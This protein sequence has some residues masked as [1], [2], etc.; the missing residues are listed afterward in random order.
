MNGPRRVTRD[1]FNPRISDVTRATSSYLMRSTP[2]KCKTKIKERLR[3]RS[4]TTLFPKTAAGFAGRPNDRYATMTDTTGTT[5]GGKRSQGTGPDGVFC[6]CC[7]SLPLRQ[8]HNSCIQPSPQ[9]CRGRTVCRL[10]PPAF[11]GHLSCS[12]LRPHESDHKAW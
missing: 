2:P 10:C 9:A 1:P 4:K 11:S 8:P 3:R 7:P 12:F 5:G 6:L